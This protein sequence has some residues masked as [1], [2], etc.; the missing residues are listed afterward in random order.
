M[1]QLVGSEI[2][3]SGSHQ[4]L[5]D[6]G[7]AIGPALGGIW[8][9]ML[10]HQ[11]TERSVQEKA[12]ARGQIGIALVDCILEMPDPVDL[13]HL[14]DPMPAALPFFL[15]AQTEMPELSTTP[16]ASPYWIHEGFSGIDL[17][18]ALI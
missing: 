10:A 7:Q 11:P 18:D 16:P 2:V 5:V 13:G 8:A 3:S 9:R 14:T 1:K 17:E 6:E 15:P 12:L 4:I